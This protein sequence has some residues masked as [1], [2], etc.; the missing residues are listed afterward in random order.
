VAFQKGREGKER[1]V[2]REGGRGGREGGRE[3]GRGEG[4]RERRKGGRERRKGGGREGG[5]ERRKGGGGGLQLVLVI[6]SRCHSCLE[7]VCTLL[8]LVHCATRAL[9]E[10]TPLKHTGPAKCVLK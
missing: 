5:R 6:G 7:H 4:G 2:G 3:E 1:E 8:R 10:C 9:F